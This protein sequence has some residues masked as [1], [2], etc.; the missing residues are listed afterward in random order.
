MVIDDTVFYVDPSSVDDLVKDFE[1]LVSKY[2][3]NPDKRHEEE[4]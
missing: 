4:A 3:I 1:S 2:A